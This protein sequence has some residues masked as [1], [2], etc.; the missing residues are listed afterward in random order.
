MNIPDGEY[1]IDVLAL[2]GNA[3][4]ALSTESLAIRYGF[5][6]DSM[7]QTRPLSLFRNDS[8]CILEAQLIDKD[9]RSSSKPASVIFEGVQQ[10]PRTSQGPTSDSYY[11]SFLP[12][13]NT[14][15]TSKVQLR[16]LGSTIRVSKTRNADKW[17]RAIAEWATA[18]A[19]DSSFS[20]GG[21]QV[22]QVSETHKNISK[23]VNDV[24]QKPP[25]A[26]R[27]GKAARTQ[28]GNSVGKQTQNARNMRLAGSRGTSTPETLL[29][30]T[31]IASE[32]SE[33]VKSAA[34]MPAKRVA[35]KGKPNLPSKQS[36]V[37]AR[38][39]VATKRSPA[40][41][42]DA[43]I[44]TAADFEDLDSEDEQ[45]KPKSHPGARESSPANKNKSDAESSMI[46]EFQD[47]EDQLEEVLEHTEPNEL[48]LRPLSDT[49]V[50]DSSDSDEDS[51]DGNTFS[52]G[53][54]IIDMGNSAPVRRSSRVRT[55]SSSNKPMSLR[56][57][58]GES[59]NE[60][61]SSSEEE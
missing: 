22:P 9:P 39:T 24:V 43:D 52:G 46:D 51:E 42:R 7:D 54:I 4:G 27:A 34:K 10:R 32:P 49:A 50:L 12:S 35:Q 1:D 57:L 29:F 3:A 53:P 59:K 47:L 48:P 25:L 5:I 38:R 15:A 55:S 41:K 60:N 6:P 56:E 58:Y 14:E 19:T 31:D 45:P 44:I 18:S 17:R 28:V 37:S 36:V 8:V 21:L 16:P 2:L 30:E 33:P 61:Y 26:S 11:L 20:E 23:S 13:Y 40:L